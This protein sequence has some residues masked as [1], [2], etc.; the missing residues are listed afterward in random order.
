MCP[1]NLSRSVPAWTEA[2]AIAVFVVLVLLTAIAYA[3]RGADL[4]LRRTVAE[5][6]QAQEL[7]TMSAVGQ[8][9]Q[10]E[11]GDPA[12]SSAELTRAVQVLARHAA[13][14]E[15]FLYIDTAARTTLVNV[16]PASQAALQ[17]TIAEYQMFLEEFDRQAQEQLP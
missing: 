17:A 4:L 16:D 13:V 5:L 14:T 1:N 15:M 3:D 8:P 9:P 2:V 6:L 12:W 11:S 10:T 7:Y